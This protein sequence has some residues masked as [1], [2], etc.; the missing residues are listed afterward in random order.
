[1]IFLQVLVGW[2]QLHILIRAILVIIIFFK[3]IPLSYLFI[4]IYNIQSFSAES[5]LQSGVVAGYK[6]LWVTFWASFLGFLMQRLSA[7]FIPVPLCAPH[8]PLLS[9]APP[10]CY[11]PMAPW[12]PLAYPVPEPRIDR[13]SASLLLWLTSD[14][15]TKLSIEVA[16]RGV[17]R[18]FSA[19]G[20]WFCF[21]RHPP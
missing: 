19:V 21:F 3:S 18:I 11:P 7:R 8:P 1:M 12:T 4:I 15:W 16:S 20:G 14:G 10:L 6:L 5:D 9:P 2:C 17:F 13:C